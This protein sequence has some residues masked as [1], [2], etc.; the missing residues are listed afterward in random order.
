MSCRKHKFFFYI[1]AALL[2]LLPCS[3]LIANAQAPTSITRPTQL[4]TAKTVFVSN[5]GY[6]DNHYSEVIYNEFRDGLT[7]WNHYQLEGAPGQAELSLE[8]SLNVLAGDVTNGSS[9]NT[10]FVRL[11][12][13]DVKT[14]ILLWTVV[15]PMKGAFRKKTGEKN[16]QDAVDRI[17]TDVK[18]LAL[19][20]PLPSNDDPNPTD[21][22]STNESDHKNKKSRLS[23]QN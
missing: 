10:T 11:D 5:A 6:V 20:A 9:F 18:S 4:Q 19:N 23:E 1:P 2:A 13:R 8:L 17:V 22:K 3:A 14:G 12:I 21:V 7:K 16:L 15:E